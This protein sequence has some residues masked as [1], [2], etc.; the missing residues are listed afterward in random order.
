MT[1]SPFRI[2]ARRALSLAF[3]SL[4]LAACDDDSVGPGNE[5][6]LTLSGNAVVE[7]FADLG[8]AG[9]ILDEGTY[10]FYAAP[11]EGETAITAVDLE[12]GVA[13]GWTRTTPESNDVGFRLDLRTNTFES[14]RLPGVDRTVVRGANALGQVVGLANVRVTSDSYGFV[15]EHSSG[16]MS[17][18]RRPGYTQGATTDITESGVMVG[19]S[20]FGSEGW[21]HRNGAFEA[22]EHPE[23]GRLFPI[24]ISEQNEIVGLW[25][26][27]AA[28]WDVSHGFRARLSGSDWIVESYRVSPDIPTT[29]NGNTETGEFAGLYWAEGLAG[30]PTVFTLEDW[31]ATPATHPLPG[32][33]LEPWV[34][35]M[36]DNGWVFGHVI[37][38]HTPVNSDECGG[39]GHLHGTECHCD[40][41]YVQDPNDAGMCIPA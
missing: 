1:L 33:T 35:G 41:G 16:A 14:L 9:F 22:L 20:A 25:G 39:N 37:I 24:E 36:A 23:A 11:G 29:L 17:E 32:T 2:D 10:H 4:V 8:A 38:D 5:L 3:V 21:V 18:V 6:P 28:W 12:A 34:D 31:A 7:D 27:P 40:T 13:W 19:Y 15:Y 26:D 30:K